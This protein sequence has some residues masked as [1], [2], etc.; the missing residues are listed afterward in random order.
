MM[1]DD[2]SI[3]PLPAL[4]RALKRVRAQHTGKLGTKAVLDQLKLWQAA[5]LPVRP[6]RWR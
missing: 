1:A 2:L 6:G 4:E 3:Y 5:W